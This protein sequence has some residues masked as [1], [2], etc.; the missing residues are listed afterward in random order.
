MRYRITFM[1]V[2]FFC[3]AEFLSA[4]KNIRFQQLSVKEGLSQNTINCIFQDSRGFMWF[5][6]QN[7][8][9]KYDGSSITV[10]KNDAKDTS[11]IAS[12]DI[13]SAFEDKNKNLWFGTSSGLSRFNR[14]TNT[15]SNFDFD[16]ASRYSMRPV[17]CIIGSSR[18]N[19]LW[20][21]ASGGLF[22]FDPSSKK[23]KHF[24]IND[25]I[26]HANSVL[27]VCEDKNGK[28]W[29]GTSDGGLLKFD[30]SNSKF[31]VPDSGLPTISTDHD[32]VNCIF[33]DS[34]GFI[35]IGKEN[36]IL[37]RYDQ[38]QNSFL[39]FRD[40]ERKYPIIEL[41]E[42]RDGQLWIGTDKGGVFLLD[43][44]RKKFN[45]LSSKPE[46]GTDV[47]L[48]LFNDAKGDIWLG[49][50]Q[51]GACLFDKMDTTF[52]YFS[53]YSEIKNA[54][55]SNSI[56]SIY[57][58]ESGLW[59]GTNGG[60]LMQLNA[61]GKK[62]YKK[63]QTRNSIAGNTIMC[64]EPLGN[65]RLVIGTYAD[66]L[67]ILDKRT[68]RIETYDQS[69]GLSDNSV[70]ALYADGDRVWI[71]TN[72]GG[73]SLFNS[74][75]RT[76]K[77]FTNNI[78]DGASISSNTIRSIY[79]DSRNK[80]WIGTVSGLNLFNE[81]DSTF[82]SFLHRD[83][84]SMMSNINVLSIYEDTKKNLWLGTHG[85][86]INKYDYRTDTFTAFQETDGLSGNIVYGVLEDAQGNLWLSTNHGISK[87][88]IERK[89][90]KNFDTGSGL[91]NA[92]F[93]V[94]SYFKNQDGKMYFGS[95]D[96]VCSFFP[97]NIRENSYLPPV[98]I[99][100]FLLFNKPVPIGNGSPLKQAITETNEIVLDHTQTVFNLKFSAL[101]FSHPDKN[102]FAY[103]LEPFDKDWNYVDNTNSA[104]YT[105]LDP[106]T[107]QFKVIGSN[108]D[109]QW[110]QNYASL[111]LIVTPPY[112]KTL[113][114][115]ALLFALGI[116]LMYSAYKL[117][118]RSIK[119][120]KAVLAHLVTE[121][122]AEIEVKSQ[123]L[124]ETEV[125]N[126][127]LVQQKLNDELALKSKEL[128]NYTLLIIQKNRLLDELKKKLKEVIRHPGSS[129][130]R[131]FK[132]LVK[133]INY[134]F[135][136]EK[137]W[138]EFNANFNR[139]HEGF[140]DS[141]KAR[142]PELTHYD[143]RLCTLYRIGIPTK[144]IAEA[145]GIS[146][147]SVK[148]ARYRLRKKLGLAPEDD[149]NEFFQNIN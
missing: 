142:F 27:T 107:Y 88:D 8:L 92:Q 48:S 56:L 138:L 147:T 73:L 99:T 140:A 35:W 121:R 69:N 134:N 1:V 52:S 24:A 7:G 17:W 41:M 84:K 109:K 68:G 16:P 127:H 137:E 136:P 120:Q 110:N 123:L 46:N 40:F 44:A 50:H 83:G 102:S 133:L 148:M 103:K 114:F 23:I 38:S 19:L 74:K 2:V 28:F 71:G 144:N 101:N 29:I 58:D 4:Q 20:I 108:N 37:T 82:T 80:L 63:S 76:F 139:V 34:E 124:L 47:V 11:S 98:V 15:F 116:S 43:K 79:K 60:G 117:K 119:K 3:S 64:I 21:G 104:T 132:N 143:L 128:T 54:D 62:L 145:M 66:G 14:L 26:Q 53:P 45:P 18:D 49:T 93:N 81:K 130:L 95:I 122:T 89:K 72:K 31:T 126:A 105:N 32:A 149:I 78:Q 112:W 90:F 25:S 77:Y 67:S 86:G 87:F 75:K 85:G 12:N 61:L 113:W 100:D 129:N 131:D 30:R 141:L 33:Q 94:G 13:Y 51:G 36:G 115:Q 42:T 55:E 39:H 146:Q 91:I 118:V 106:G 59:I 5:G 22:S 97:Y 65:D 96:G 70:Y 111:T 10:F 57:E 125:K 9:N 6:T 135:S